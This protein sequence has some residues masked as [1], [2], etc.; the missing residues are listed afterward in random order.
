MFTAAHPYL[1]RWEETTYQLL[2]N[3]F[4]VWKF[5]WGNTPFTSATTL[6]SPPSLF[7]PSPSFL[8]CLSRSPSPPP[9]SLNH[10]HSLI[11][12]PDVQDPCHRNPGVWSPSQPRWEDKCQGA[13]RTLCWGPH[14]DVSPKS[15]YGALQVLTVLQTTLPLGQQCLKPLANGCPAS[16]TWVWSILSPKHK[17]ISIRAERDEPSLCT[18]LPIRWDA[19]PA[20]LSWCPP[21][22]NHGSQKLY[23]HLHYF[24]LTMLLPL[25][26]AVYI[27]ISAFPVSEQRHSKVTGHRC[28]KLQGHVVEVNGAIVR[29]KQRLW[30]CC[31]LFKRVL[32]L[33]PLKMLE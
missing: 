32:F 1:C 20:Q 28:P 4:I 14:L 27:I 24:T 31:D 6:P 17:C 33:F 5:I 2:C 18:N 25:P 22:G 8:L 9:P 29:L 26:T 12:S 21:A 30:P 23:F 7:P 11:L 3:K 16:G 19:L 15:F 10:N 13:R